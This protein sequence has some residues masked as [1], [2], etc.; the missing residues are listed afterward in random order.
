MIWHILTGEYPPQYGG[1][2]D[3]TRQVAGGLVEAG[4]DVHVWAPPVYGSDSGE[5]AGSSAI[6]VHRL[7]DHFGFRSLRQLAAALDR[8][9]A[10][11]RLLVQY[12]PH[13]FGHRGANVPFCAWL[14]SRTYDA[15]WVMFHEVAYPFDRSEP[16]A[17]NALAA[18][19]RLMAS[20]VASAAER[21]F[22]SIPGWEA[23]V[24]PLVE[25]GTP[26]E[27]LPVPS[28]IPVIADPAGVARVRA[29]FAPDA[30]LVGHFGTCGSHIVPLLEAALP[31]L[32]AAS[33]CRMLLIGRRSDETA[34][35]MVESCAAL[36]GRLFAT[37]AITAADVSR[38]VSACDLLLQPYPDG[39]SSRRTSAMAALSHARAMVT[40][41]GW[42]TESVWDERA[43]AVLVPADD[44]SALAAAAASLLV[45]P[46]RRARLGERAVALYRDRFD[47]IHTIDA[48]RAA[49]A[50]GA[51]V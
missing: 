49:V 17:R 29:S 27:W 50:A 2:S 4:D 38:A 51:M 7:P 30:P 39:V 6:H 32:A 19:N 22:V 37:G 1:V 34:A 8:F 21:V 24:R 25:A 18:V 20:L 40:T 47:V 33:N 10:P 5:P 41:S 31:P 15:V 36:R 11:R 14:R 23:Q 43:A 3:Y 13:A 28:A 48:L 45:D 9:P 42:L 35:K 16:L 44:P 12:V 46:E 26:I